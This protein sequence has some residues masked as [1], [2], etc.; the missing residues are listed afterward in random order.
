MKTINWIFIICLVFFTHS[1]A[2]GNL[3]KCK[4]SDFSK[5]MNCYGEAKNFKTNGAF[6]IDYYGSFG[7]NPGVRDGFGVSEIFNNGKKER[8]F[9]GEFKN[10]KPHGIGLEIFAYQ[11]AK[12][13]SKFLNGEM[14]YSYHLYPNGAGYTGPI[15]NFLRHGIGLARMDDG[16]EGLVR[17]E[18]DKPIKVVKYSSYS[19]EEIEARNFEAK[20]KSILECKELGFNI[21]KKDFTEC[22][23]QLYTLYKEE[24][25]ETQKI[26]TAERQAAAAKKQAIA[27]QKQAKAAEE[28]ARQSRIK[29][30]NAL[31]KKGMN[32]LSGNCTLGVNC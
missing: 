28:Q 20:A 21:G 7:N 10:N 26:K 17:F 30:S 24:A 6:R 3:P 13:V 27:A 12:T 23:V 14:L 15:K 1:F 11:D 32:M 5:W 31:M 18:N 25:L 4:G 2:D 22:S 29:N 16:K 9:E 19:N 8:T